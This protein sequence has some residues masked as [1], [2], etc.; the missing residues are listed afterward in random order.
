MSLAYP[1]YEVLMCTYNGAAYVGEQLESILLQQPPPLRVL[2]SDD[3]STDT[4]LTI[5]KQIA[6]SVKIPIDIICGPQNGI[7]SNLISALAHTE[8][9]YVLLADQDDIWLAEK[10]ALFCEKMLV[11]PEP[12]LIFSDALVWDPNSNSRIPFWQYDGLSPGNSQDPRKLAFHNCI[13]G[14]SMAVNQALIKRIVMHTDIAM[15]DWWIGLIASSL[16]SVTIISQPTLL[17]RQ[18]EHNQIGSQQAKKQPLNL[19]HK[20]QK[21]ELVLRQACAFSQLYGSHARGAVTEFFTA[22]NLAMHGNALNKI[23]FLVRYTPVRKNFLRTLT[24]WG[25]I[26]FIRFDEGKES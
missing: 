8:A 12:H 16:G 24:L 5:V 26:L 23:I 7:V 2:V 6:S 11:T 4:T 25:S 3:G 9:D 13:Q 20:K 14:A 19:V 10:A 21:A 15:H 1:T 22:F 17:Y 18:H